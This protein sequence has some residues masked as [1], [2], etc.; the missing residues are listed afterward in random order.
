[1]THPRVFEVPSTLLSAIRF[2]AKIRSLSNAIWLAPGTMQW[3][4]FI[5]IME[6]IK[7]T[8][9]DMPDA[10]H[11]VLAMEGRSEWVAA[12]N[13]FKRFKGLKV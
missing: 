7:A 2:T 3:K 12:D 9:N 6:Q 10:Y 11:R 1:M 4:F 13:G 8:G 5:G